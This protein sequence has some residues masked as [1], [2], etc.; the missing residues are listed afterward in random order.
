MHSRVIFFVGIYIIITKT[1]LLQK[2]SYTHY[3]FPMCSMIIIIGKKSNN[4]LLKDEHGRK[5]KNY[6]K[7]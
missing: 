6:H 3:F 1:S 7:M 2:I 4:C 5:N